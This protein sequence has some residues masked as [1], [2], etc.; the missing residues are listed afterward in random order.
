MFKREEAVLDPKVR[1]K[2]P[3]ESGSW[4]TA[5]SG[6]SNEER[7]PQDECIEAKIREIAYDLW[8]AV[9]QKTNLSMTAQ[10]LLGNRVVLD[11]RL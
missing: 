1:R 9:P 4:R 3:S 6:E 11:T 2:T 7:R 10:P 5:A 8:I